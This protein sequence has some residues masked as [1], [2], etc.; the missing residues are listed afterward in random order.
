[1]AWENLSGSH[2]AVLYQQGTP[3]TGSANGKPTSNAVILEADWVPWGKD[4]CWLQPLANLKFGLQYT[5]YTEFNGGT[6]N[7]D[8][9][10][11]SASDSNTLF[12]YAWLTI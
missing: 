7:Y 3:L 2:D 9:F 5:I 1:M 8:G 10:G 11:R 4:H 6:R 12:L